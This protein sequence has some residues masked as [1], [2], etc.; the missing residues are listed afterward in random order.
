MI[1]RYYPRQ[2]ISSREKIMSEASVDAPRNVRK[3]R[4]QVWSVIIGMSIFHLACLSVVFT[5]VSAVAVWVAVGMYVFRGL[6]VTGGY[7]RLLAHRSFKTNRF[8]QFLLAFAGS[9]AVQGGPLWWVAH[10]RAHHAE[11]DTE[12][13]IHSPVTRGMWAAH[14]GWMMTDEAFNEKGTNSRD[15]HKFP[16]IKF[17]Q[18]HYVWLILGQ[19]A[20]LYGLGAWLQASAPQLGTSGPQM[21]VWGFFVSTVFTWHITFM[22]NSVCHRWGAQPY[23]TGDASTNNVFI[24]YLG[25]GEGWHNNHHFYPSSARHGLRWWQLDLTWW[26]IR[27]LSALGL[28]RDL[29]LPKELRQPQSD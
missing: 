8:I 17:L 16:E 10:H 28:A 7:H 21:L 13:D 24:G 19:M 2:P 14:M 11:T 6:G 1:L 26:L 3:A 9:L 15:L 12:A 27:G 4:G 18:R 20:A 29:K 25:F 22:V 5:G 23:D